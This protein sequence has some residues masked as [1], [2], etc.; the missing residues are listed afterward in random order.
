M[1]FVYLECGKRPMYSTSATPYIVNGDKALP[2]SWPWQVLLLNNDEGSYCGAT[3]VDQH[4]V[5]TAAHCVIRQATPPPHTL[6]F[7]FS[8]FNFL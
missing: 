8:K 5:L 2:G 7:V 4:W 6:C 3:I 1:Y